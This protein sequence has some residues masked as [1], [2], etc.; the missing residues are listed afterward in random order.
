[1]RSI[2]DTSAVDVELI[3][4]R[5]LAAIAR[6]GSFSRAGESLRLSQP[7][8]SHHIRHLEQTLGARVLERSGKHARVT[9]AG[10]LML[11]RSR[12]IFDEL[13]AA[14]QE[15]ERL[16]GVVSGRVRVGTGATAS[17]YLLPQLLRRLRRRYPGLELIVVTG[18]APDI[19][20]GVARG[21]LDLGVVTLP[22]PEAR[23]DVVPFWDDPMVA[24]APAEGPWHVRRPAAPA[25]LGTVPLIVYERGGSIR[26]V[27]EDWFRRAGVV[28]RI[29]MELG[30]AEAIKEL[31]AAGLGVAIT[32]AIT[33]TAHASSGAITLVPLRPPLS[34]RLG[35]IRKKRA[36]TRPSVQLVLEALT[37]Y[38]PAGRSARRRTR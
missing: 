19:A 11:A 37:G 24:I 16:R 6:H 31:V 38:K 35:I 10:E 15:I 32:S 27:I 34:R 20:A 21:D 1:M 28:P 29:V 13:E 9:R 2:R 12:R 7:A 4:L 18:N 36:S 23:L 5:T 30:N 17:I 8:V 26:R 3:H 14:A 33:M 22:V 25:D